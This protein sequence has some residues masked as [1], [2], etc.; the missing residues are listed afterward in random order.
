MNLI[1]PSDGGESSSVGEKKRESQDEMVIRCTVA[2]LFKKCPDKNWDDTKVG[3]MQGRSYRVNKKNDTFINDFL[4]RIP[5]RNCTIL[6]FTI[7]W[8]WTQ[9]ADTAI[10]CVHTLLLFAISLGVHD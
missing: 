2:D 9:H 7:F 6:L 1:L 8:Q 4:K 3:P 5:D 10:N